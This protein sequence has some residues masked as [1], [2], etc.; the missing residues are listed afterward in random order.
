MS[1]LPVYEVLA[2]AFAAEGVDQMFALLG[3]A[4]MHWGTC[5][6]RTHNVRIVHARHEH[7]AVAMA[8][9]YARATGRVGVATTTCGPGFTQILTA[10]TVAA[11]HGSPLVIFAGDTPT[12]EAFHVQ[13]FDQKPVALAAGARFIALR[14]MGRLLQEVRDAF[15]L[16][17]HES[18]PVV[19]NVPQDLQMQIFPYMTDYEPSS[20]VMPKAQ[21]PRPDVEL[22]AEAAS[23]L[24]TAERPIILAGEGAVRSGA[25]ASLQALGEASGAL[26]A[27]TLR[28]KGLFDRDPFNIGLSGAFAHDTARELF[29]EADCVA[30]FG[31]GLGYFTTEGGYLFPAARSIQVD[32]HPRGVWQG[33]RTADLHIVSDAD[34]AAREITQLLLDKGPARE[35]FRTPEISQRVAA[36]LPETRELP[37][38]AGTLDPRHAVLEIDSVIPK[39]WS[40]VTGVGHFFNWVTHIRGRDAE[41]Y[42]IT[43]DFGAIGQGLP[44]AIGVAAA[45]SDGKVVLIEGDG[46]L[47]MHIQELEVLTR[48]GIK[49]LVVVLN[50]GAYGAEVHKLKAAGIDT[51][52]VVFG[53]TDL[54][55]IGGSFGLDSATVSTAGQMASLLERHVSGGGSTLWD[56]HIAG[57]VP[58]AQYRRV[59]FGQE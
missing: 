8:D 3:D 51:S 46:S 35:G 36:M 38:E 44:S 2:Q 6:A 52:E 19:L 50:D 30:A 24:A 57:N 45:A 11:R 27:T 33:Q 34:V 5:M 40:V 25:L 31:T 26:L 42:F 41:R 49:L 32:L 15:Y 17:K 28:A 12:T 13:S 47:L 55:A 43:H 9:G 48:Q 58:S 16:A 20:S 37:G 14:D 54:A 10:L 56:V 4:N 21:R 1:D 7:S 29:A 23:M 18:C 59:Y 39:D 53:R 22:I